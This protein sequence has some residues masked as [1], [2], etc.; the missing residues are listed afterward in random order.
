MTTTTCQAEHH[1]QQLQNVCTF[2]FRGLIHHDV[3][4][5]RAQ[6]SLSKFEKTEVAQGT[7]SDRNRIKLEIITKKIPNI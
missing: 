1:I 5:A 6:I 4:Y 2:Q 3:L 7:L